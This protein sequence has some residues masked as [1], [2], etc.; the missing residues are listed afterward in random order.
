MPLNH[1]LA[2]SRR[3][4]RDSTDA[5]RRLWSRLRD[6]RLG[7][8]KFRRQF[9]V[10]RYVM[11]FYC[12]EARLGIE[13]DGG[14]HFTDQGLARDRERSRVLGA[15]GIRVVRFTDS[16]VLNQIDDVL[17]A[18][19]RVIGPES[20]LTPALSQRE[21]R[22]ALGNGDALLT[23]AR[24]SEESEHG[25]RDADGA[26]TPALSQREREI[27]TPRRTSDAPAAGT[28]PLPRGEG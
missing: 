17:A 26:L 12:N 14:Q 1:N 18:I 2:L 19:L 11:D 6:R 27:E 8:L 22:G 20:A 15:A 23:A 21:R 4:R 3:L 25:R 5:E 13:L 24:T 16:E 28:F 7:G 9:P 10:D